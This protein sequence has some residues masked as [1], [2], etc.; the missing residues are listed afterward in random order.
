MKTVTQ[1]RKNSGVP[2]NNPYV[3]GIAGTDTFK[4]LEACA[5]LRTY[6]KKCGAD[7]PSS[8]RGTELRKEM[9]TSSYMDNMDDPEVD[10]LANFMGHARKIYDEYYRV[11][12]ATRDIVRMSKIL[13]K[14]AEKPQVKIS[15]NINQYNIYNKV[16]RNNS[17]LGILM[18]Y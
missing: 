12:G 10:E 7:L 16:E 17:H 18:N 13:R 3:F 9:A 8:L 4:Q 2:E 1:F 5:L 11:R 6:S 15:G 14:D